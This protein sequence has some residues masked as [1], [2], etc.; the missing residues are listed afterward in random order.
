MALHLHRI[1]KPPTARCLQCNEWHESVHHFLTE[2]LKYAGQRV[3]LRA[4]IG[5]RAN[6]L[7]NL[8]N[9]RKCSNSITCINY[10][11]ALGWRLCPRSRLGHYHSRYHISRIQTQIRYIL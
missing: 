6:Q 4:E 2:Y 9:D 5:S 7:R 3:A 11:P 8:L 10:Q 1:S